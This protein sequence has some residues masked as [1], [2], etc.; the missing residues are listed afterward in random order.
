ML[1]EIREW[2]YLREIHKLFDDTNDWLEKQLGVPICT[3]NCGICCSVN[4]VT[5]HTIEASLM[6]SSLVGMY[7]NYVDAARA[8][9][10]DQHKGVT[11]YKG[12]PRGLITGKLR[13]E[14]DTLTRQP[15]IFLT[16]DM[17]CAN[18]TMRPLPC[19]AY[20]VTKMASA[21]CPRPIGA[22]ESR[23]GRQYVRGER[24]R[25]IRQEVECFIKTVGGRN[26]DGVKMGLMP[27][28]LFRQAREKEFRGLIE[29][30]RI[31]SAKLVGTSF[32]TQALW[33]EEPIDLVEA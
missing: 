8:W 13:E 21:Y 9:L 19:R 30:N 11:L 24:Q 1:Q 23:D 4:T 29:D 17:R 12:M 20:G 14:W 2:I 31:A 32:S 22:G 5:I 28:M 33:Q 26:P 10:L 25:H 3:P 16:L 27:T 6:L 7:P 15:C 18:Y